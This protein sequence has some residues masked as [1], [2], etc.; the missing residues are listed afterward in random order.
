MLIKVLYIWRTQHNLNYLTL[1]DYEIPIL[2]RG[3]TKRMSINTQ[4][5]VAVT[6]YFYVGLSGVNTGC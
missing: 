6:T 5:R 3:C 4:K 2:K 1:Y